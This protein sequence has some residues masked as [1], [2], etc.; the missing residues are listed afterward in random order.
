[1]KEKYELENQKVPKGIIVIIIKKKKPK[2]TLHQ[3]I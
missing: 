3:L 2:N 1:M